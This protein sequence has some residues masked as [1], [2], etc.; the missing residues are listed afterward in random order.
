[1]AEICLAESWD[2][3]VQRAQLAAEHAIDVAAVFGRVDKAA[4]VVL[5]RRLVEGGW[6]RPWRGCGLGSGDGLSGGDSGYGGVDEFPD[7][8]VVMLG[9]GG[10]DQR[11]D[12]VEPQVVVVVV[13]IVLQRSFQLYEIVSQR[14]VTVAR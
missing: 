2:A 1:M 7:A 8:C 6:H 11:C 5:P 14:T 13:I 9:E 3:D 4:G 12:I 10:S